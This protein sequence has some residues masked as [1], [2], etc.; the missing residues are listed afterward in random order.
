MTPNL[1]SKLENLLFISSKPISQKRLA[2]LFQVQEDEIAQAIQE[3]LE[4]YKSQNKGIQIIENGK[5]IEMVTN[6]ENAELAR[7]FLKED[8]NSDL[9]QAGLETLTIIAYRGPIA[10]SDLEQIRG[11]N[12]SLILRNLMI[13]GLIEEARDEKRMTTQYIVSIDFIRYLGINKIEELP[14]YS[15]LRSHENLVKLLE[16]Q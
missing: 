16:K 2:D 10:K 3:L 12:C 9:T 4:E 13:K 14:D 11:V 15:A 6:P 1:K 8:L 7:N 5:K